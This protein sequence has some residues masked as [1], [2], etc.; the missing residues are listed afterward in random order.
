MGGV[1]ALVRGSAAAALFA[2]NCDSGAPAP[3][4]EFVTVSE[5]PTQSRHQLF[6]LSSVTYFL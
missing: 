3:P 5:E 6:D 1:R 4:L 2:A